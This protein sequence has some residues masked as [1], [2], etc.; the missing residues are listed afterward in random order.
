[1]KVQPSDALIVVDVQNDFCPGGA[2]AVDEG[3]RVAPVIN[4][5]MPL[6]E[7]VVF[8]RDWHPEDHC[9]FADP[10]EF[11]NGSWPVH[12]VANSPGAEFHGSLEVPSDAIIIDKGTDPD[13]EAYSG[14]SGTNLAEQLRKRGVQRVFICGLATE[15]CVKQTALDALKNGFRAVLIENGCRGVNFPPGSAALAVE[16]MKASGVELHWSRDL[17]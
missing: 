5:V 4:Q 3:E 8:T 11:T 2:L 14:F 12:C 16:E 9:S 7:H 6:F 1:M 13:E 10:P 15:Y 17:E